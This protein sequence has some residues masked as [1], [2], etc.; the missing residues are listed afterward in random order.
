[1]KRLVMFVVHFSVGLAIFVLLIYWNSL[2]IVDIRLIMDL[3]NLFPFCDL[4]I[5][6]YFAEQ[7]LLILRWINLSFL[8]FRLVF[9]SL[10]KLSFSKVIKIQPLFSFKHFKAFPVTCMALTIWNLFFVHGVK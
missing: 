3:E 1:M 2:Y 8:A 4:S 6:L 10:K 7:E 9:F 5:H